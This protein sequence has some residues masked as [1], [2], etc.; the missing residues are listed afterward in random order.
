MGNKHVKAK[1]AILAGARDSRILPILVFGLGLAISIAAF[2][3]ARHGEYA[4]VS[5][6]LDQIAAP[7][8]QASLGRTMDR[9]TDELRSVGGLFRASME[10]DENEFRD[11]TRPFVERENALSALGWIPA[12]P[13]AG[14]MPPGAPRYELTHVELGIG[15]DMSVRYELDSDPE[16]L[17][18]IL[19]AQ[20]TRE[21]TATGQ[22]RTPLHGEH[23]GILLVFP[24]MRVDATGAGEA[25][26]IFGFAVAAI[27]FQTVMQF[28]LRDLAMEPVDAYVLDRS[29]K[30]PV[31][32]YESNPA[33]ATHHPLIRQI[34]SAQSMRFDYVREI[35]FTAGGREWEV[36]LVPS[37]EFIASRL[38]WLPQTILITGSILAVLLASIMDMQ[39]RA[40]RRSKS[41]AAAQQRAKELLE[42]EVEDRKQVEATLRESEE[43][44][45]TVIENVP[46]VT[47][48]CRPDGEFTMMYM[49]GSVEEVLG[50]PA[51]EFIENRARSFFSIV[52]PEDRGAVMEAVALSIRH[53]TPCTVEFRIV[54]PDGGSIWVGLRGRIVRDE[55]GAIASLDGALMDITELKYFQEQLH[56]AKERAD[57]ANHAKGEFLARMSHEIRT[58]MNAI[59][60]MSRLALDTPLP[61]DARHYIANVHGAANSLLGIINDVLDFSKIEAGKLDIEVVPFDLL[62]M[63]DKASGMLFPKAFDKGLEFIVLTGEDTPRYVAGDPLRLN[64]VILNLLGNAIK[65]TEHGLVTL[66]VKRIHGGDANLTLQFEVADTGIGLTPE[67]LTQLFEPFHQAD[68]STTR[69]F[70]G[71]GLGLSICKRLAEMMGGRIWVESVSGVGTTFYFTGIFGTTN[72][73]G[74][75]RQDAPE[76]LRGRRALVV[77]D[78]EYARGVFSAI[79]TDFG[80]EVI[81]TASAESALACMEPGIAPELILIDYVLPAMDG[82]TLAQHLI[83]G[84][85]ASPPKIIMV[86]AFRNAE[87]MENARR[88]GVSDFLIKPVRDTML[89]EATARAFG[90]GPARVPLPHERVQ[91]QEPAATLDSIRGARILLVED[92]EMNRELAVTILEKAGFSVR[93]ATTGREALEEALSQTFDLVLMDIEMP[94][95]DGIQAARRLRAEG[96]EFPIVAMTAHA[97]QRDRDRSL[98]AGM[99]AHLTKPIEPAELFRT[100]VACLGSKGGGTRTVVEPPRFGLRSVAASALPPF[101]GLDLEAGVSYAGGSVELYVDFLKSF[102]LK[103]ADIRAQIDAE[104]EAGNTKEAFRL[105][106]NLKSVTG[107]IG[108]LKLSNAV[109]RLEEGLRREDWGGVDRCKEEVLDE[110]E[111]LIAGLATYDWPAGSSANS[112]EA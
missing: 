84:K 90:L 78:N 19:R 5:R 6:D 102:V 27:S 83:E 12:P 36:T 48:R 9:F 77:E 41:H 29:V 17:A 72:M 18:A 103:Y 7:R 93:V 88:A 44:Y 96:Y 59:I 42:R 111:Q 16:S 98:A 30:P 52:E 26:K 25:D 65:F 39:Q 100:L 105:A 60:G 15:D 80:F 37:V 23:P 3:L 92:N 89:W 62:E 38:S 87:V 85:R 61:D 73:H 106:H 108:A 54:R 64:Q 112:T 32:F 21:V 8:L 55:T 97:M 86:S 109:G 71:T 2:I 75:L 49:A 4:G 28:A 40:G 70:G 81:K 79:L 46:G 58:P 95:M 50:R 31:L 94:D 14:E 20:E 53:N 66:S 57:E 45:R 101:P 69:R 24:V 51:A 10:V 43:K 34:Q 99:N 74:M 1:G 110:V 91:R 13:P 63:L 82:L 22:V 56:R 33:L 67:Q 68:Q 35:P 47:L 76:S 11:F 104:L 107:M